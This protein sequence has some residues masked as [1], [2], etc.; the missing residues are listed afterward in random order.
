MKSINT[1]LRY[2]KIPG[3]VYTTADLVVGDRVKYS[4]EIWWILEKRTTAVILYSKY[5]DAIVFTT[6]SPTK[7]IFVDN[8]MPS[9][10]LIDQASKHQKSIL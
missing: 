4:T 6:R 3:N 7:V 5:S 9:K 8:K 10:E 2:A 1:I